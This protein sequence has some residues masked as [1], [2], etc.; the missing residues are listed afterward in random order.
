MKYIIIL[1]LLVFCINTDKGV[2]GTVSSL[3][4]EGEAIPE[5]LTL[6]IAIQTALEKNPQLAS[7]RKNI[8]AAEGRIKQSQLRP[9]P[10][11]EYN[12]EEVP[13]HGTNGIDLGKG[14]NTLG[15]GQL[16]ET[17]GKRRLRTE[18]ARK[19]KT[20][21]EFEYE[22]LALNIESETKRA[23][24]E[25][26]A[27]REGL[28]ITEETLNIARNLEDAARKRFEAG[29]IPQV[30]VFKAE[31]EAARS[32]NDKTNAEAELLNAQKRLF[33]VMG[34]PEVQPREPVGALSKET[35]I[36]DLDK[37]QTYLLQ[38]YPLLEAGKQNIE[39]ANTI[40]KQ[41][42][43]E[44]IPNLDISAG[45]GRD[46]G[47][48]E[49]IA[50]FAVAVPF[51]LFNRNQGKIAESRALAAKAER[52][53]RVVYNNLLLQLNQ[54]FSTYSAQS[55]QVKVFIESILPR[56]EQSLNL[57]T[58]GYKEGEFS[59][60]DV[61]DAQRTLAQA[62]ASYISTLKGLNV[63]IAELEKLTGKKITEIS[64]E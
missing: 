49:D 21:A 5:T 27:A 44:V 6:D 29:D 48:E 60:L 36:L 25:V 20:V 33:T 10:R 18:V 38:N 12:A 42:K 47:V 62:R 34:E 30:E 61:L 57:A 41:A 59:Y 39:L 17:G 22:T 23:F 24:Y 53:Y 1:F 28:K 19:E 40:I 63:T 16:F 32:I 54:T 37:L 46:G 31:V 35:P 52:D 51:P 56:A 8:A 50:R 58:D 11:L 13:G 64:H 4:A 43:R 7:M 26:L 15:I 3:R 2:C 9:N 45:Y 14:Q 55:K